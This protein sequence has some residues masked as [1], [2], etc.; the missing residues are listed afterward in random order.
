MAETLAQFIEFLS[1]PEGESLLAT[2]T[3]LGRDGPERCMKLRAQFPD[4]DADQ[5]WYVAAL[6]DLRERAAGKFPQ[7]ERLFFIEEPLEQ[8]TA[9][10]LAR[11]R[12]RRFRAGDRTL[13]LCAGLGGDTIAVAAAAEHV[14]AVENDP[15]TA[16]CLAANARHL[17]LNVTVV[18]QNARAFLESAGRFDAVM[19]DPS[20]RLDGERSRDPH[21]TWPPFELWR[22]IMARTTN[23]LVVKL[24]PLVSEGDLP[25]GCDAEFVSFRGE[26]RELVVWFGEWA[27]GLRR[28]T[29]VV[30]E[31]GHAVC[32]Q[33]PRGAADETP[34][35]ADEFGPFVFEP[36]PAVIRAGLIGLLAGLTGL[37]GVDPAIAYL[38]G[39]RNV[40]SPFLRCYRVLDADVYNEKRLR[41]KLRE[42]EVGE[43][44][45]LKRGF[46][47]A[48]EAML[49]RLKPRGPNPATI[50]LTRVGERHFCLF[51]EL[52]EA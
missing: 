45:I 28:A 15:A 5:A 21:V 20:R 11:C 40:A 8:A 10:P 35:P 29:R 48:P 33:A 3:P 43:L 38:T 4:M 39:D 42:R 37:R 2:A 25:A 17:G 14:T 47:E 36:D 34:E 44:T 51:V 19:F 26:C 18:A 23:R 49:K 7:A 41:R 32:L 50:L 22:G 30:D 52:E 46:P 24:S 13:D 9:A 31:T 1:S 6:P 16:A 12:A 27:A